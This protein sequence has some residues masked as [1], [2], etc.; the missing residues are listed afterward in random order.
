LKRYL[1]EE[2]TDLQ[3]VHPSLTAFFNAS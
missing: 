2:I 1:E 3:I